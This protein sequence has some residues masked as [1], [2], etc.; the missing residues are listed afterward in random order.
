MTNEEATLIYTINVPENMEKITELFISKC[1]ELI[2]LFDLK[3]KDYG[4]SNISEFGRV[5]VLIRMNDKMARIKNLTKNGQYFLF[6]DSNKA[7]PL[8]ETIM[9]EQDESIR[10]N[11]KN[12]AVYAIIDW[13]LEDG[14][15]K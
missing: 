6:K 14:L 7:N 13:L 11:Y 12:I 10:D 8:E 3:Q 2:K 5:G 15:W 4:S 1:V 9:V